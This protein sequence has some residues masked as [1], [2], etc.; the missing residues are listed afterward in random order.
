MSD[1][2]ILNSSLLAQSATGALV[3]VWNALWPYLLIF[4]GFSA[5][6]FVHELGHFLAAKWM[7]VR[8]DR[9]AIGFMSEVVGFTRGETRYSFNI[10]PLGGYVKMLG[11]EDFDDKTLELK[12]PNDPRS[13]GNKTVLQRM[14]IVSAGVIMNVIF[15]ALMFVIVFMHG[16]DE[17]GST[18]GYVLPES[19]AAL[20]GLQPGDHITSIDGRHIESFQELTYAIL[21]APP[22]RALEFD[23]LR[24]DESHT[25]LVKPQPD[26]Q[27]NLLK[28]GI[29][30]ATTSAV[31]FP[32]DSRF[33]V[34]NP[35]HL[36]AGD[37]II[38]IEGKPIEGDPP[39]GIE[40]FM[41]SPNGFPMTV[42]VERHTVLGDP[43]SP[44]E[45]RDVTLFNIMLV[46]PSDP[47][48][49]I[50]SRNIL[51]LASLVQINGLDLRGRAALAG[52]K[53]GD[54]ILQFGDHRLPTQREIVETVRNSVDPLDPNR[55]ATWRQR[56]F[57]YFSWNP[58]TDIAVVVSR[59]GV[60]KPINLTIT[61]EVRDKDKL[62]LAGF[63]MGGAAGD[64]LRIAEVQEYVHGQLTP[65]A[66]A[67]IPGGALI[68][69][70][71]DS[72]V[73]SWPE[74]VEAFRTSAGTT[75]KLHYETIDGEKQV[76]D[77]SLPHSIRT[78]LGLTTLGNI[79]AI[80][81]RRTVKIEGRTKRVLLA[82]SHS[83]GTYELLRQAVER[84]NNEPTSVHVNYQEKLF[85][86]ELEAD[87]VV[88]KDMIDPWL[89][90]VQYAPE[91]IMGNRTELFKA[92]GPLD[93][94]RMGIDKTWY[95]VMQVYTMM[96]RMIVSRSVGVDK[97]SGPV[98][99]VKIGGDMARVGYI[100][101]FYFLAIISANLAVI[102]FLPL[103]VVDGGLMVFL[104]IEKIK[105]SPV[106]MKVQ[107]ATQV[108]GLVLIGAAF[109]FV[110]FQD[111]VRLAG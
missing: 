81:G 34:D 33:D 20:A 8:V 42:T 85:G 107:I 98:G 44:V 95:F 24:G 40:E 67:G 50:D 64:V 15:A 68:T 4:A 100:Q 16:K 66:A 9:F 56:L 110:T 43:D 7:D 3:S 17:L 88:T 63:T 28:V 71:D 21:L 22:H 14:V 11:Q 27:D 106:S 62:P 58:E 83:L 80:D 101:L 2:L 75:V 103:P 37:K 78:K 23:F 26:Q 60:S 51:G 74:L 1:L 90:R 99:I 65:A 82:A 55:D 94:L 86:P 70:I 13:F 102:N 92:T 10:L 93:A 35:D 47:I 12:A 18:I 89:G 36:Q 72:P 54:V 96:E 30:P 25:V 61:P 32:L 41:R 49:D 104:I 69:A 91:V 29:R 53:R 39:G 38:A 97:M 31:S 108:I 19:P 73:S 52:L 59:P 57:D 111:V 87:I 48:D 46:V 84:N 45:I 77:F 109:L 79:V 6:I 5:V 76:A 105:G